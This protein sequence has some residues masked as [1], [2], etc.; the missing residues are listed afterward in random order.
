MSIG[1]PREIL[2]VKGVNERCGHDSDDRVV[3]A[4]TVEK[5]TCSG[6]SEDNEPA[7]YRDE[8]SPY[9]ESLCMRAQAKS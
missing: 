3:D 7:G 9:D 4:L 1:A 5:P 6:R 2:D 8:A